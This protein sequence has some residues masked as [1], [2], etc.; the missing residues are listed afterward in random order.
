MRE[1]VVGY[2]GSESARRALERAAHLVENGSAVTVVSAVHLLAG[3]GG[4]THDPVEKEEHARRLEAA[5]RHL[6]ALGVE[7]RLVE[8]FG[9]PAKVITAQAESTGADLIVVGT[10]HRNIVE[11]L[12]QGSVSSGVA[13]RAPCDVLIV[14]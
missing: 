3:K 12:L 1:I 2:D 9:D 10:E 4:V 5:G 7:A 13:H 6:A 14:R 11:R 8:G